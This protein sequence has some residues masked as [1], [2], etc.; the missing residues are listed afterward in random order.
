M[1][2]IIKCPFCKTEFE[3]YSSQWRPFCSERCKMV[4]LGH[5]LQ[6]SYRIPE[7]KTSQDLKEEEND[8]NEI[9]KNEE[10]ND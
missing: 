7:S 4:D 3:Y 10:E 1:A 9:Q 2:R 6:E 5:W 8:D